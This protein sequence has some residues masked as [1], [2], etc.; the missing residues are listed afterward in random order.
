MLNKLLE[1]RFYKYLKAFKELIGVLLFV[2]S[3]VLPPLRPDLVTV[4]REEHFAI[5]LSV[6]TQSL[7]ELQSDQSG[8]T[9][10]TIELINR[11]YAPIQG[12]ELIVNGV[13]EVAVSA[14]TSTSLKLRK[15]A[16]DLG[17]IEAT[18]KQSFHF[19]NI[20]N[21]PPRQAILVQI[22]GRLNEQWMSAPRVQVTSSA[23]SS[24]VIQMTQVS[25][26][27]GFVYENSGILVAIALV[28]LVGIG[29][30]RLTSDDKAE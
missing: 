27:F 26:L 6:V 11:T 14:A 19:P 2:A 8:L 22:V 30:W 21:V 20:E 9:L 18:S 24:R 29:L 28:F 25:G 3:F 23:K 12:V 16:L 10:L 7:T 1:S 5:P 4:V 15:E 17:K 13:D